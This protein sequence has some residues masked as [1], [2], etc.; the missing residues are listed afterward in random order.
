[1]AC[2]DFLVLFLSAVLPFLS[3]DDLL[4]RLFL[5]YFLYWFSPL[6]SAHVAEISNAA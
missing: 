3:R 2:G 1:L 6:F 4:F 5:F